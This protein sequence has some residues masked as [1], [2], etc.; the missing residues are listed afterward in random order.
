[1]TCWFF[2]LDELNFKRVRS[3]RCSRI[4]LRL[5]G[6]LLAPPVRPDFLPNRILQLQT[7]FRNG[8]FLGLEFDKRLARL[9]C[10]EIGRVESGG[11]RF[12]GR[13]RRRLRFDLRRRIFDAQRRNRGF[14]SR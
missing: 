1:M 5:L 14:D 8:C 13:R 7:P 10:T 9:F 4:H 12:R 2:V 3:A 6:V 11:D